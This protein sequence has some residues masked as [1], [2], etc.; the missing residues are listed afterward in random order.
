ML[1]LVFDAVEETACQGKKAT[2]PEHGLRP[3]TFLVR[4]IDKTS[5]RDVHTCDDCRDEVFHGLRSEIEF[6]KETRE[7]EQRNEV[8]SASHPERHPSVHG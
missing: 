3:A 6:A 7:N 5:I 4:G 1:T 2:S 8:E